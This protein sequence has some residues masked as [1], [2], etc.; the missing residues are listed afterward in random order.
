MYYVVLLHKCILFCYQATSN[1]AK[2]F[3][4]MWVKASFLVNEQLV[5]ICQR[6]YMKQTLKQQLEV[7]LY[8][9]EKVIQ[10]R[11]RISD[12]LNISGSFTCSRMLFKF[13]HF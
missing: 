4:V 3:E 5:P 6:R 1:D 12:G 10:R 2:W 11:S 9:V 8:Y 13:Q 7:L